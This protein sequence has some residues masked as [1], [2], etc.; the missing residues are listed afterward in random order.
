MEDKKLG[1]NQFLTVLAEGLKAFKWF[2]LQKVFSEAFKVLKENVK[3]FRWPSKVA[4]LSYSKRHDIKDNTIDWKI[5]SQ[6]IQTHL[7]CFQDF[8]IKAR[9]KMQLYHKMV[10]S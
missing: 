1:S 4:V 7:S 10:T 2:A 8:F 3:A 5:L 9:S 6:N